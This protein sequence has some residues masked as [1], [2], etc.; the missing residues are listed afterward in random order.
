[1]RSGDLNTLT[2]ISTAL[3]LLKARW[4][5]LGLTYLVVIAYSS[6]NS[7]ELMTERAE[8]E[9]H[10]LW[11]KAVELASVP[12]ASKDLAWAI[13]VEH[14]V[15]APF[16]AYWALQNL[17]EELVGPNG[18]TIEP[19]VHAQLIQ[20]LQITLKRY[21]FEV[22]LDYEVDRKTIQ[23][24]RIHLY[25]NTPSIDLVVM[26]PLGI[27]LNLR[28]LLSTQNTSLFIKDMEVTN[29]RYSR[30]KKRFYQKY[31]KNNDWRGL[32][33][34]LTKKNNRFFYSFC[35]PDD[36]KIDAPVYIQTSCLN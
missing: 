18:A 24:L 13:R 27:S 35:R 19:V 3:V 9:F 11:G 30:W 14:E 26:G 20:A 1:M 15:A 4:L 10:Q 6:A 2:P 28:Y 7:P 8:N 25:T 34:A 32:I 33:D 21:V 16:L 36:N 12:A 29:I 23:D 22:L 5:F 17:L 31:A